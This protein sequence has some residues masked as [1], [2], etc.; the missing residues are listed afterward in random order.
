MKKKVVGDSETLGPNSIALKN[1][2]KNRSKFRSKI[3]PAAW[4]NGGGG[5][6]DRFFVRIFDR[7][8]KA[9]E[10]G[11]RLSFYKVNGLSA[12]FD[13]LKK[14][15]QIFFLGHGQAQVRAQPGFQAQPGLQ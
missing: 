2:L 13:F 4:R 10:L 11:P 6:L 8:F 1:R 9:S 7:F 5:D 15:S 14:M 3:P 12:G